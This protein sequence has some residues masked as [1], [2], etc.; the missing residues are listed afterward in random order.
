MVSS[1]QIGVECGYNE[2][3]KKNKKGVNGRATF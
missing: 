1:M 2:G 3:L